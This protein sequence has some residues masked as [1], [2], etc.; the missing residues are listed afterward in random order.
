M[1][2]RPH[3]ETIHTEELRFR[4]RPAGPADDSELILA[5]TIFLPAG[6]DHRDPALPGLV[7]GHGAGSNR[8][9]HEAFC[10][11]A[12]SEGM[13]VMALD[14]RGHGESGGEANGPLHHDITAAADLLRSHP[15]VDANRIGYRGSSMGGYYGLRAAL[16]SRFA[17]LALLCPAHEGILLQALDNP[18]PPQE[19]ESR[20]LKA[21]FAVEESR[22]Y[23]QGRDIMEEAEDLNIPTLLAHAR[24][25]DVVPV[26]VTL[27]LAKR[28][29]GDT[30]VIILGA[31]DH[32]S[33]QSDARMHRRV[34]AWLKNRLSP[35]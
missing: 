11:T 28:L 3:N 1:A 19:M 20:G 32:S 14:M 34:A 8:R 13:V 5:G 10:R 16:D 6:A 27:E 17:A 12:C 30:E 22:L 29:R 25:D 7:V 26:E 2:Q 9:R 21:H 15:L 23:L 31:G 33:L 35:A 24:H 4:S 18:P